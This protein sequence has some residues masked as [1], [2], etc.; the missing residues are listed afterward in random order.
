MRNAK[1]IAILGAILLLALLVF[2]ATRPQQGQSAQAD[3]SRALDA[4]STH[5][6]ETLQAEAT[7]TAH[8]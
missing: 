3:T 6:V 5:T 7:L 1:I 8:P 2:V 4:Y